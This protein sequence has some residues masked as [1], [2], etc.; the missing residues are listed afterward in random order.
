MSER[1][2]LAAHPVIRF[3]PDPEFQPVE[4]IDENGNLVGIAADYLKLL[5]TKLAIS[6]KM[7]T[8]SSWDQALSMAR[9]REVD[10]L[11]AATKSA[12][13]SKFMLFTTPHIELPGVI[14]VQNTAGKISSLK[15]FG[16]K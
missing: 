14:I 2:W 6:F 7:V 8:V 10:M 3:A 1:Q 4:S 16:G 11:S 15:Q 9:N 12:A 13:R 5:E